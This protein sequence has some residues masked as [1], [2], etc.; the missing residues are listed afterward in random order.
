MVL[1]S[2]SLASQSGLE[3]YM[4]HTRWTLH[5]QFSCGLLDSFKNIKLNIESQLSWTCI[6]VSGIDKKTGPPL[7]FKLEIETTG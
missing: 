4:V 5:I 3:S 7:L 6:V 1:T 2:T